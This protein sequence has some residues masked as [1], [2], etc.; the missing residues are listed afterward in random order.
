[1]FDGID[2]AALF[3]WLT[4]LNLSVEGNFSVNL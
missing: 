3:I 1:M 4:K 2:M